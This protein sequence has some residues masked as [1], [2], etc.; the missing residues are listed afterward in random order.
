MIQGAPLLR[1]ELDRELRALVEKKSAVIRAWIEAGKLAPV[2]AHHLIFALWAVTQ[3]YADFGVQ[4][5]ALTGRTLDDAAFFEQTV[6]NVQRI[7]LQ[8]IAPR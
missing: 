8:G 2:D 4:V 6:E 1:D 7:V 5:Q 3:H